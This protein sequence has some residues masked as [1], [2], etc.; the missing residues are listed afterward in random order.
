[1]P[2]MRSALLLSLVV[3]LACAPAGTPG[4]P[5][6]ITGTITR[7]TDTTTGLQILVEADPSAPSGGAKASV[8]VDGSTRIFGGGVTDAQRNAS[9]ADLVTGMEVSVWFDGPAAMSYPVQAKAA[10]IF[11]TSAPARPVPRSATPSRP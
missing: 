1:M 11:V 4:R 7:V 5:A 3:A 8:R 10:T 6:D 9:A 2:V